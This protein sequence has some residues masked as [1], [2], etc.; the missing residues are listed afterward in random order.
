MEGRTFDAINDGVDYYLDAMLLVELVFEWPV[1]VVEQNRSPDG[2]SSSS[3][4]VRTHGGLRVID[5]RWGVEEVETVFALVVWEISPI[6]LGP[7]PVNGCSQ[8]PFFSVHALNRIGVLP[9]TLW[10]QLMARDGED[11]GLVVGVVDVVMI[12][13][14]GV[15]AIALSSVVAHGCLFRIVVD[16]FGGAQPVREIIASNTQDGRTDLFLC[17]PGV[18]HAPGLPSKISPPWIHQDSTAVRDAG[19]P[20]GR[21]AYPILTGTGR[22]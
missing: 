1:V 19:V 20:F 9:E 17:R 7:G 12:I 22:A 18:M 11:E 10:V 5:R 6:S 21:D 16:V 13:A 14:V 8:M 2:C 3:A 4:V 15:S